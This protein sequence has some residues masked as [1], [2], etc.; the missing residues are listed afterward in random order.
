M[1]D[2]TLTL[3]KQ[4]AAGVA[5]Q[6]GSNCEVAVHDLDGALD[7]HTIVAIENGHVTSRALGDGPSHA[8]LQAL[9]ADPA[10]LR[11]QLCYLTRTDDG[12]I[13]R[14]STI[15][16][17]DGG[18]VVSVFAINYDITALVM[19]QS[20]LSDLTVAG[21]SERE[22]ERIVQNVGD[23]LDELIRQSE[24]LTG[25]PA[26]VMTKDDKVRAIQFLSDSGAFLIKKS[27]EK[28]CKYFGISKYTLY[29]YI[30]VTKNDVD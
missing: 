18:R 3:L 9:R 7:E 22:P 4:L 1:N 14:S 8:V 30:D 27:S 15:F 23:L 28:V 12:R 20:A 17:R 5:A 29:N 19:A 13:L 10:K 21:D 25:K 24:D 6:F 2:N 11:D 26:A 16:V